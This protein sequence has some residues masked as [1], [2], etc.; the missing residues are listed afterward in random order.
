MTFINILT[1]IAMIVAPIAAVGI[2]QWLP[3]KEELRKDKLAIFK[4]LMIA[5]GGWT[6]E[7]FKAL[8]I[9]DIVFADDSNV[10]KCWK[11]YYNNLCIENPSASEETNIQISQVKLLEAM[12]KSLG[13]KDTITWE[14]IQKP[15]RPK[16]MVD[17]EHIQH[18]YQNGQIA[19]AQLAKILTDYVKAN[20]NVALKTLFPTT[21]EKDR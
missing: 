14:T 2:G 19:M 20:P 8:N 4:S 3:K 11:E 5:R 7:S 17:A 21:I 18:E 1:I 10:R 12:A 16:G 15:Y 6:V 13:Y 9:I